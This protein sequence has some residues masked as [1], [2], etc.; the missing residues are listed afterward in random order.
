MHERGSTRV[1]LL[2]PWVVLLILLAMTFSGIRFPKM[3]FIPEIRSAIRPVIDAGVSLAVVLY[4][5]IKIIGPFE[6]TRQAKWLKPEVRRATFWSVLALFVLI[7]GL[8]AGALYENYRSYDP[9]S[10]DFSFGFRMGMYFTLSLAA[11]LRFR[12]PS[13]E[14]AGKSPD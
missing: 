11:V 3:P 5:A 8:T 13:S 10:L 9:Y 14:S 7:A 12:N 4:F 2:V 6:P 1:K